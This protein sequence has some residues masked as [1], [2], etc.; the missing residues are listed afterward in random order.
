[1]AERPQL[2][3]F[4]TGGA[5]PNPTGPQAVVTSAQ[6][7]LAARLPSNVYLGTSSWTFTG[8]S[9]VLY[10]GRPSIV[11]NKAEGCAPQTVFSLAAHLADDA[12]G[13]SE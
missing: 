5:V 6:R 8:W 11:G 9:G 3:L 10:A 1:M 12:S 7:E 13:R 4:Q 2:S